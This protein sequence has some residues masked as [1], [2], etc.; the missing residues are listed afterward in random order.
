MSCE[1]NNSRKAE[2]GD[3]GL[4]VLVDGGIR[5]HKWVRGVYVW[6]EREAYPV[7]IPI[8]DAEVMHIPQAI[9]SVNQPNS[10]SVNSCGIV[11]TSCKLSHVDPSQRSHCTLP[12]F[13]ISD[14]LS[15]ASL[16]HI[17]PDECNGASGTLTLRTIS[18]SSVVSTPTTLMAMTP[19]T[20]C[21]P[22]CWHRLHMRF[23]LSLSNTPRCVWTLG[24][25]RQLHV[26]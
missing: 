8:G 5:L 21:I 2:A 12:M 13:P 19:F 16:Q 1:A 20:I 22:R 10:A 11:T 15:V 14:S 9:R 17:H 24:L 6:F 23:L 18:C 4:Q 25:Q 7:Q 3:A 26:V